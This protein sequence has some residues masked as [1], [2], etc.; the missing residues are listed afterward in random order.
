MRMLLAVDDSESARVAASAVKL[1]GQPDDLLLL[2]VVDVA[3]YQ[4]PSM[5]PRLSKDYYGR[6]QDCLVG[7]ARHLLDE[8]KASFPRDF[9]SVKT[10]VVVGDPVKMIL[11]TAKRHNP[12]L[13]VLGSRDLDVVQ[14]WVVGGVSYQVASQ[15][16]CPVLLIKKP[17]EKIQNILL[18]YD[19]SDEADRAADFLERGIFRGRV[20]AAIVTVWPEQP[21]IS[22]E[23]KSDAQSFMMR[24][25]LAAAELAEKIKR[26][27]PSQRFTCTV[28]V[29][30]GEPGKTLVRVA[31]ERNMD[32]VVIGARRLSRLR[33]FF[34]GSVSH[35]VVHKAPCAVLV[36]RSKG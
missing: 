18:A 1:L 2:H 10:S 25:K 24:V 30:E 22:P 36:V 28:E 20:E 7:T 9:R 34:L 16:P 6:L 19:G 17:L 35:T 31:Q 27:L 4:H 23:M 5:P 13:L 21:V 11:D 32:L 8:I 29:A 3:R 12:D 14:E 15:A 33:R 26:R